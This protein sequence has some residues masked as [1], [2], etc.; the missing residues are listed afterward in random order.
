MTRDE[1]ARYVS[2][3]VLAA[4]EDL[5]GS[6]EM[7]R[8]QLEG[9]PWAVLEIGLFNLR[10]RVDKVLAFKVDGRTR[11]PLTRETQERTAAEF[12]VP[13]DLSGL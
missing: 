12:E 10:A 8:G 1:N 11:V 2:P 13:D 3:D 4:I 9:V 6:V 5:R 7:V